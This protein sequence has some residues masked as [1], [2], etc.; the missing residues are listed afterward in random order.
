MR[1]LSHP[2]ASA[3]NVE[4]VITAWLVFAFNYTRSPDAPVSVHF[5]HQCLTHVE[6]YEA[7]FRCPVYFNDNFNGVKLKTRSLTVPIVSANQDIL[8]L[9]TSH[10]EHQ[11]ALKR[12]NASIDIIHQFIVEQLP[13]GVPS[14]ELVAGH[15]GVS[16]RQ[17]QRQFKDH[18]TNLSQLIETIRQHL[19]VSYLS[20]TSHKLLYI[21]TMLGYSE[22][23][24]FQRAFK[25]WFDITPQEYRSHPKPLNF[26]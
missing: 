10:A 8:N 19:A 6:E 17:L 16:S 9:L 23:S 13:H 4:L 15:L 11:L 5:T 26:T 18:E 25:R 21:S 14:L 22:Q 1:W 3:N 20:Q 2:N 24:A 7:L 12:Q